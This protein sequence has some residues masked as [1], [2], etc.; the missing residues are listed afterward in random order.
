[1]CG[2]GWEGIFG[3]GGWCYRKPICMTWWGK[4]NLRVSTLTLGPVK[5]LISALVGI[6]LKSALF[7]KTVLKICSCLSYVQSVKQHCHLSS[8]LNHFR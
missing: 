7:L 4:K 6:L 3:G 2:W 8:P 1:M 5:Y